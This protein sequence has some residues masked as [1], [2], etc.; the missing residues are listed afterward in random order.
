MPSFIMLK[1]KL[2]PNENAFVRKDFEFGGC[3]RRPGPPLPFPRFQDLSTLR[4]RDEFHATAR[5]II[6]VGNLKKVIVKCRNL[7]RRSQ[8]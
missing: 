6:L 7:P 5:G 2:G 8:Q 4:V 1:P 3:T